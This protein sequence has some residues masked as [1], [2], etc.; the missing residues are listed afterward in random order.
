ML[1]SKTDTLEGSF[2]WGLIR[3]LQKA[4]IDDGSSSDWSFAQVVP[5]VLL[6]APLLTIFD[7]FLQGNVLPYA[8]GRTV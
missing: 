8:P 2:T 3:L 1:I 4:Q 5:I 6:A 7:P